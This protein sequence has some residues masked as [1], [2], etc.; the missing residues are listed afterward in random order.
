M[1]SN[2]VF[3][4]NTKNQIELRFYFKTPTAI[5]IHNRKNKETCYLQNTQSLSLKLLTAPENVQV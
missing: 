3:K 1:E 5:A 2:M 4:Q